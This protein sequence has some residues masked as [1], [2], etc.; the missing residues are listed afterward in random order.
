MKCEKYLNLIDDLVEGE[1]DEQSAQHLHLHVFA[2]SECA[3]LYEILKQ[4]KQIYARYLF[5]A[6]PS[7]DL[8]SKF[9]AKLESEINNVSQIVQKPARVSFWRAHTNGFWRSS[10]ALAGTGLLILFGLGFAFLNFAPFGKIMENEYASIAESNNP[11]LVKVQT[12]QSES[13]ETFEN[14]SDNRATR[15]GSS[16]KNFVSLKEV[17]NKLDT[18]LLHT[19]N[20][21]P[22]IIQKAEFETVQTKKNKISANR[23]KDLSNL[24]QLTK[25]EQMQILQVKTLEKETVKQIEKIEMLLRS[26]R[27]ARSVEG[28]EAFDVAYEKQQARKLLEKNVQLR[29]GAEDYG[30]LYTEEILSKA[31]PH[32]LDIA[33]LENNPAPEKVLGIKE[34]VK[35]Q[36]IIA[37]LQIY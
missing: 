24:A 3:S 2:C 14:L 15:I 16:N 30:A 27:N 36:N 22:A 13:R 17:K 34:R 10:T 31:E 8:R 4:E 19:K 37:S 20:I 23:P 29:R 33:N 12:A 6:E 11:K 21:A 25:D 18:K 5:D 26:F 9:Q 7:N 28:G 35:N 32:L 1:L